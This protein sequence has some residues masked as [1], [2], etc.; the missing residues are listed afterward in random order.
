MLQQNE[1]VEETKKRN[2]EL[3]MEI[4]RKAIVDAEYKQLDASLKELRAAERRTVAK[5]DIQ[6]KYSLRFMKT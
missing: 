6:K 2:R 5:R 4:S 3:Q 1:K